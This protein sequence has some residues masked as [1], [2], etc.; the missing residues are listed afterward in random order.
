MFKH[1]V[2]H[3]HSCYPR[4]F[5]NYFVSKKPFGNHHFSDRDHN[6][7]EHLAQFPE[8]LKI[9]SV[10]YNHI[11]ELEILELHH[12]EE[13][14][15]DWN[16]IDSIEE[17]AF[18][19]CGSSL[20]TLTLSHNKL[21]S[22]APL[23]LCTRLQILDVS[24]NELREIESI[25]G[26]EHLIELNVAKNDLEILSSSLLQFPRLLKLNVS[27][28]SIGH[29]A[30]EQDHP[31]VD[32][33]N[34]S[35]NDLTSLEGLRAFPQLTNVNLDQ[36]SLTSLE[37][38][39][40]N[41]SNVR[42]LSVA[43]NTLYSDGG[44]ED[45]DVSN[46][47]MGEGM[48]ALVE[49]PEMPYLQECNAADNRLTTLAHFADCPQLT[50]L[51]LSNNQIESLEN[52]NDCEMLM[53]LD[54]NNNM[55]FDAAMRFE[56][57]LPRLH[58]LL[59]CNNGIEDLQT[60][61]QFL[62]ELP[63]LRRLDVRGNPLT[64]FY[65]DVAVGRARATLG[66]EA[67]YQNI[68][69]YNEVIG[70]DAVDTY[71]VRMQ[72]RLMI[73]NR[74]GT[75]LK[76]LDHIRVSEAEVD[77]S[78]DD[79]YTTVMLR[80]DGQKPWPHVNVQD[81]NTTE[82]TSNELKETEVVM[83]GSP[84]PELNSDD[85]S[86]GSSSSMSAYLSAASN[87][88][89]ES[90]QNVVVKSAEQEAQAALAALDN[91]L[92]DS[93]ERPPS[94]SSSSGGSS[95][96][97]DDERTDQMSSPPS[98]P[99][100]EED[101]DGDQFVDAQSQHSVEDILEKMQQLGIGEKEKG[102]QQAQSDSDWMMDGQPDNVSSSDESSSDVSGYLSNASGT[103]SMSAKPMGVDTMM[104]E[105]PEA[106][107]V[108]PTSVP[109]N[110]Q[111]TREM[112]MNIEKGLTKEEKEA[113]RLSV[114]F[115][116]GLVAKNVDEL[117]EAMRRQ[118][119]QPEIDRLGHVFQVKHGDA[120][121]QESTATTTTTTSTGHEQDVVDLAK[122][123]FNVDVETELTN[124][125]RPIDRLM[126]IDSQPPSVPSDSDVEEDVVSKPPSVHSESEVE[127]DV[128]SKPPSIHSESE[129]EE[130]VV[131]KPPS[132]HSESEVEEDVV[133]KPPSV[134][135]ESEVE[136]DVVSKPPSVHSES[137]VEEDVV[138]KP[139]SVH[140]ESEVEEGQ[141][142]QEGVRGYDSDALSHPPSVKS[143]SDYDSDVLKPTERDESE[144]IL[145]PPSAQFVEREVSDAQ[146]VQGYDSDALSH[147]PSVKST[148]DYDSDRVK[149]T[150]TYESDALSH[151]PSVKSTS[152]YDSDVSKPPTVPSST[153][154][155]ESDFMSKPPTVVSSSES[156]TVLPVGG[157]QKEPKK[158][159]S[160]DQ[161]SDDTSLF[162]DAETMDH[163]LIIGNG[164]VSR[165]HQGLL[166]E[167][168]AV[169]DLAVL[170]TTATDMVGRRNTSELFAPEK[171][172]PSSPISGDGD[173]DR[174]NRVVANSDS[175]SKTN[176]SMQ[177]SPVNWAD[178]TELRHAQKIGILSDEATSRLQFLMEYERRMEMEKR[179]HEEQQK[180][181]DQEKRRIAQQQEE[182]RRWKQEQKEFEQQRQQQQQ[183]QQ[184]GKE[185][186]QPRKEI[187]QESEFMD[188]LYQG[189]QGYPNKWTDNESITKHKAAGANVLWSKFAGVRDPENE[190]EV[191]GG[192]GTAAAWKG[193]RTLNAYF[194][195]PPTVVGLL[196]GQDQVLASVAHK[197]LT[198]QFLELS[199]M[200]KSK[201]SDGIVPTERE[202]QSVD[203]ELLKHHVS[204]FGGEAFWLSAE[205]DTI[206]EH[207]AKEEEAKRQG[208]QVD[209]E[210]PAPLNSMFGFEPNARFQELYKRSAAR[211][212][213]VQE[214]SEKR[215]QHE[216]EKKRSATREEINQ[217][218]ARKRELKQELARRRRQ[219]MEEERELE[220][221]AQ[222]ALH[223]LGHIHG[224]KL[225]ASKLSPEKARRKSSKRN[226]G[227]LA[228]KQ[229]EAEQRRRVKEFERKISHV[230][231]HVQHQ[232][233]QKTKKKGRGK[234]KKRGNK[235]HDRVPELRQQTWEPIG[236]QTVSEL[237]AK[238]SS[239]KSRSV[240]HRS[241]SEKEEEE[242]FLFT[243]GEQENKER[244]EELRLLQ[245]RLKGRQGQED[246]TTTIPDN[247]SRS[248][249]PSRK[250]KGLGG[251]SRKTDGGVVGG[252]RASDSL[253]PPSGKSMTGGSRARSSSEA[254]ASRFHS[255][256]KNTSSSSSNGSPPPREVRRLSSS[257]VGE[258]KRR[259]SFSEI[260]F[261]KL[262]DNAN[263]EIER[264]QQLEYQLTKKKDIDMLRGS[265]GSTSSI[266]SASSTDEQYPSGLRS[267]SPSSVVSKEDPTELQSLF[268]QIIQEETDL[269][270]AA[271]DEAA[272]EQKLKE[273]QELMEMVAKCASIQPVEP[274]FETK[275]GTIVKNLDV[276]DPEFA[277]INKIVSLQQQ[278]TSSNGSSGNTTSSVK[279]K[280]A[281]DKVCKA[282]R[283][284]DVEQYFALNRQQKER[285][286]KGM[287]YQRPKLLFHSAS[288]Q[289]LMTKVLYH[290]FKFYEEMGSEEDDYEQDAMLVF[291]SG[292]QAL[293]ERIQLDSSMAIAGEMR[294]IVSVV[295]LGRCRTTLESMEDFL[296]RYRVLKSNTKEMAVVIVSASRWKRLSREQQ[297]ERVEEEPSIIDSLILDLEMGDIDSVAFAD[298]S[299][300][301]DVEEEDEEND[302]TEAKTTEKFISSN[303][304]W[305]GFIESDS[306][307]PKSHPMTSQAFDSTKKYFVKDAARCLAGFLVQLSV[308]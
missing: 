226:K 32:T 238:Y 139:P 59:L 121:V 115:Q 302:E 40:D 188:I 171:Y 132:V 119:E 231:S 19:I 255:I 146:R 18:K 138:S 240:S 157:R 284:D 126:S 161:D 120:Q 68:N 127:E 180:Q 194:V 236:N 195:V 216:A 228:R 57:Q 272:Q 268:G 179:L 290:G 159:H 253:L 20:K 80:Q 130:D 144:A 181:L 24:D 164:G 235:G 192:I 204:A 77:L 261:T 13:L 107:A 273:G 174:D 97:G 227:K 140:S 44:Y 191:P 186:T 104:K 258:G 103:K 299:T 283:K 14:K 170:D 212:K 96:D 72:Y 143:T 176:R 266:S 244:L 307:P 221:K 224:D 38:W 42:I 93:N 190:M 35:D 73:L 206:Q 5:S 48:T 79:N 153:T 137:E 61:V 178:L 128:V 150:K 29:I 155:D 197:K 200:S 45:V 279:R 113:H 151:P 3:S 242:V 177:T 219:R 184:N 82:M 94:V 46:M 189:S 247:Q 114:E 241:T 292:V 156:E 50:S 168:I 163:H 285:K 26:M 183:R 63:R 230:T 286:G 246:G 215:Q 117:E 41:L 259:V 172:V 21:E 102:E 276:D 89:M 16:V 154:G 122:Q 278:M 209:E 239:V 66:D 64:S 31:S 269:E 298:E 173:S 291:E 223:A 199:L 7:I 213:K 111:T 36:N 56:C 234:G 88:D 147:P 275:Y 22:I 65:P 214:N 34:L 15:L 83:G 105:A 182:H 53:H 196:N 217:A 263:E 1:T 270:D 166:D 78:T 106:S 70:G 141:S 11:D 210:E 142:K 23:H 108:S 300:V 71:D 43:G 251:V 109:V 62:A 9:L 250:P 218:L 58:T 249:H 282:Y 37:D 95:D 225:L 55:L 243:D 4:L 129:V 202:L 91:D 262:I 17:N 304:G 85:S 123:M 27:N 87:N 280:L 33:L 99:S 74:L 47:S 125:R 49:V 233:P 110:Y 175:F 2:S 205:R 288:H 257:D 133:S 265:R 10:Q 145:N 158:M 25:E 152:D 305:R 112:W 293:H 12:L 8:S 116:E 306:P 51:Q 271:V 252:W 260:D 274:F 39:E 301:V 6:A 229:K 75:H 254:D 54:L 248:V 131:S 98:L 30:L 198:R 84:E 149:S 207:V 208:K 67:I 308:V 289:S 101:E 193:Q 167:S 90:S 287:R 187:E 211:Q 52:L 60:V 237:M 86:D 203:K 201:I 256:L 136:E 303:S 267:N 92:F 295:D 134:H 165:G 28:N 245:S 169:S 124:E 162:V 277:A 100:S 135:S 185:N 81:M 69:E 294:M 118:G 264:Q 148:S 232:S 160:D 222:A 220:V 76:L 297:E 296:E 281:V